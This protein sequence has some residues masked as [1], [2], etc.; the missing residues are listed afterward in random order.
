LISIGQVLGWRLL[1]EML[2]VPLGVLGFAGACL[3]AVLML[4]RFVAPYSEENPNSPSPVRFTR[5]AWLAPLLAGVVL[6]MVW[7]YVPRPQA[8]LAQASPTWQLPEELEADPWPL[9]SGELEW[10]GQDGAVSASRWRFKW[11]GASGSMLLVTSPTWRAHHRPE[12]CFQV[13]G[14]SV[15]QSFSYLV[16]DDFP[17]RLLTLKA[18]N[19]GGRLSAAYWLQT[20]QQATDDYATRI[21]ADL[22]PQRQ[23]WVLITILFD[24]ATDPRSADSQSLYSAL[25]QSLKRGLEEG[26]RP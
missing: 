13:Y 3:A 19:Q 2:H 17:I 10:L 4:R 9:T 8:V 7:L 22:S 1:A 14:L 18:S 15:D 16:A 5:P 23:N 20:G 11:R 24:E 25:R 21:W 6:V 12:Q 26:M